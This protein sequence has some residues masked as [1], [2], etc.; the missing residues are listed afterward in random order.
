VVSHKSSEQAAITAA[1]SAD[2]VA[3]AGDRGLANP[4]HTRAALQSDSYTGREAVVRSATDSTAGAALQPMQISESTLSPKKSLDDLSKA[5]VIAD[6]PRP[7]EA[8]LDTSK[9]EPRPITS[10]EKPKI[11]V[12]FADT[13]EQQGKKPDLIVKA[14]G[15]VEMLN[16][17]EKFSNGAITVGM[18]RVPGTTTP[19]DAQQQ[20]VTALYKYLDTRLKE[21]NPALADKG[22]ALE[23]PQGLVPEKVAADQRGNK[24]GS[25][26]PDGADSGAVQSGNRFSGSRSGGH[27][28]SNQVGDMFPGRDFKSRNGKVDAVE[29]TK[30]TVSSLNG[31][32]GNHEFVGYRRGRGHAVGAY[33]MTADQF[34]NW[35]SGVDIADLEEKERKGLIPAGTAAKMKKMKEQLAKGETPDVLKKMKDT[36]QGKLTDTD[37]KEITDTFGKQVQELAATDLINKYSKDISAQNG[38]K[39]V[40]P[41]QL[42]LAMHLGKVPDATDMADA[43]NKDYMSAARNKFQLAAGAT[44]NRGEGFDWNGDSNGIVAASRD[45]NGEVKWQRFAA[46]VQGGRLGCAASVSQVL[47]E[48]GV[49]VTPDA[50]ANSLAQQLL[51]RG[52]QKIRISEAR[53]GDVIYGGAIGARGGG[54]A[55]IGIVERINGGQMYVGANSSSRGTW[56]S[57]QPMMNAFGR[58][59]RSGNSELYAIRLPGANNNA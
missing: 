48:A 51:A 32:R 19:T 15:R 25:N 47:R 17:P 12:G 45:A 54:S 42:A 36:E 18:E 50:G 30:D 44:A 41:G 9:P 11:E 58:F 16:D 52:G 38:G 8:M 7:V 49:N 34:S 27:L 26:V 2:H 29:L 53:P 4:H 23:N 55:H 39:E 59:L 31:S 28:D 6:R 56:K 1:P 3:D 43:S 14:D 22:V 21:Q 10:F 20:S 57:D 33:G 13:L 24:P 5:G 40:D 35:L 37:K 46:S